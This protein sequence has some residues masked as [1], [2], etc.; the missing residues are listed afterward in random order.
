MIGVD[1]GTTSLRAY[2]MTEA[3]QIIARASAPSGVLQVAPG[4]FPNVL[5]TIIGDWLADGEHEPTRQME[6]KSFDRLQREGIF[7]ALDTF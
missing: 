1:W 7:H 6:K 3:G 2:R 5:R 4:D